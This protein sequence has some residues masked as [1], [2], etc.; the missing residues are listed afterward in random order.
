MQNDNVAVSSTR[1][2]LRLLLPLVLGAV[3]LCA[4][5]IL[6]YF[7]STHYPAM[8]WFGNNVDYHLLGSLATVLFAAIF[9]CVVYVILRVAVRSN[10]S[11]RRFASYCVAILS[12]ALVIS[13]ALM[14]VPFVAAGWKITGYNDPKGYAPYTWGELGSFLHSF[15]MFWCDTGFYVTIMSLAAF[16]GIFM[17]KPDAFTRLQRRLYGGFAAVALV[18][19]LGL[20]LPIW[21]WISYWIFD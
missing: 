13:V 11:S 12:F 8:D 18:Y 5:A 14:V 15:A 17:A 4:W 10:Q 9:A 19:V 1:L 3:L 16:L 2:K 7:P 20:L 6:M 21:P